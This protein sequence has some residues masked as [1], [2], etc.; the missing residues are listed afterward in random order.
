MTVN[1]KKSYFQILL[2]TC[3]NDQWEEEN[4][5]TMMISRLF[6]TARSITEPCNYFQTTGK[7]LSGTPVLSSLRHLAYLQSKNVVPSPEP[8]VIPKWCKRN[9][10]KKANL[11]VV[12]RQLTA[13]QRPNWRACDSVQNSHVLSR[14][15]NWNYQWSYPA[16]LIKTAYPRPLSDIR[17]TS[18]HAG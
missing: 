1:L 5:T 6:Y 13:L 14:G 7:S 17:N 4:K 10:T 11:S 9:T 15:N 16:T 18:I 8:K 3:E 2:H 12:H